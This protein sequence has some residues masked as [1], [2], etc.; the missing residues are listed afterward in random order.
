MLQDEILTAMMGGRMEHAELFPK[1]E[2]VPSALLAATRRT[3]QKLPFVFNAEQRSFC[4]KVEHS[5]AG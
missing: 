1:A 5:C 3:E 4:W 2:H